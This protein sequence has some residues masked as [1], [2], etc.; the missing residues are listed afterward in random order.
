MIPIPIA[1][2]LIG[3]EEISAVREVLT[4][5]RLTMGPHLEEFE[6]EFASFTGSEHAIAVNSGTSALICSLLAASVKGDIITT[7]FTFISSASSILFTGCR[8]VFVDID[9]DYNINE[10]KIADSITDTTAALL[11]VHLYGNPCDVR[12][13]SDL[14]EDHDLVLIEDACQ[15]HGAEF[16]GQKVGTF[17]IGCFSFYPT[18][19]M[20]TAEGGMITTSDSR[21]AEKIRLL[22]NVGQGSAYE[23]RALGYNLRM[24][25]LSAAMG[26][27]QLR[28]LDEFNRIRIENA[29]YLSKK[30]QS[31]EGIDVPRVEKGKKHV[32]HQYTVRITDSFP[33]SRDELQKALTER[34][35]GCRVYYPEPLHHLPMFSSFAH[36]DLT[37]SEKASAQVLS[38]PIHPA[39]SRDQLD[40]IATCI[41]DLS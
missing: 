41:G 33:L 38:L 21:I 13:L 10:E 29:D 15:A 18:K 8:P 37:Q 26:R 28:K 23:Y 14:A 2:P 22:R 1:Q 25:E 5:G 4:S 17:G 34:G 39:V 35:I 12:L 24:T 9:A 16:N 11:P 7:P 20:T 19:N 40:Y 3:E 27:I 36:P 31:V 32:F 6:R 30:L